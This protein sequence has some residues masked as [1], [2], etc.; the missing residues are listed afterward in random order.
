MNFERMWE[1]QSM[2]HRD[3]RLGIDDNKIGWG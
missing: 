3:G 1:L 2:D